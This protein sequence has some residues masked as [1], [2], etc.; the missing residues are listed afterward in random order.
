[1]F[2]MSY[3]I[4]IAFHPHFNFDRILVQ[5]SFCHSK[6]QLT[7]VNY[8]TR[9][10]FTFKTPELKKNNFMIKLYMFLKKHQTMH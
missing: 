7:S 4:I 10:Q 2:V 6:E 1:M 9:E 3:V 5:R 8:L